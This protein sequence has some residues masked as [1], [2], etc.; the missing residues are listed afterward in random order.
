M[1]LLC[2]DINNNK[3]GDLPELTNRL[4]EVRYNSFFYYTC[5]YNFKAISIQVMRGHNHL[6]SS[7]TVS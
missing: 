4:I 2:P 5:K 6:Y 3:I 7:V 1:T